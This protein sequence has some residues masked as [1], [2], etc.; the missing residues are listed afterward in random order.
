MRTLEEP[1]VESR[2][3]LTRWRL[4]LLAMA[5]LIAPSIRAW[6]S[7]GNP[8]TLVLIAA[9]AALFLLVVSRMAGLVRQEERTASRELALRSAGVDLVAAAGGDQVGAA[10]VSAVEALVEGPASVHLLLIKDDGAVVAASSAG[11]GERAV[12]RDLNRWLRAVPAAT[13]SSRSRRSP[14][15]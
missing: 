12:S 15:S 9:S 11:G 10:A 5:C 2:A 13:S 1:A 14:R 8:D 4:A 3:R 7:W 6:Q